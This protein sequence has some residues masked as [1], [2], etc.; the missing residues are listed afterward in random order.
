MKGGRVLF[1]VDAKKTSLSGR[2]YIYVSK[3]DLEKLVRNAS[4]LNAQ[5]L[6]AYG[7][8]RT[9]VHVAFPDELMK[10]E[11]KNVRLNEGMDLE[12]FLKNYNAP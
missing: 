11:G 5:P 4:T 8:S 6:V 2:K 12:G 7:F 1:V 9:D 10:A 3:D